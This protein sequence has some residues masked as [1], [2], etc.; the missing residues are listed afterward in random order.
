MGLIGWSWLFLVF[1]IGLMIAFGIW[2]TNEGE[3]RR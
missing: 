2:G 1:Y 3:E